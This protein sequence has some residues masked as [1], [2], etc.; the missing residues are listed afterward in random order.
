MDL[1]PAD[2]ALDER[3]RSASAVLLPIGSLEQ[4]GPH[5]PL[6]TDTVVAAT[7]AAEIAAAHPVRR[8]PPVTFSCSHEHAAWPGTVSLSATTLVA[9][10][11]DVAASLHRSGAGALVLVNG[12][13]GNYVL[14]NVVQEASL[15]PL[16][17][18]LFPGE[19]DWDAARAAA[20]CVT[21]GRSDMHAGE[22]ETSILLHAHPHLV[23]PHGPELDHLAD[24]RPHLLSR[25]LRAYTESGVV[26]R[27]SL[28]TAAKGRD[29]LAALVASFADHL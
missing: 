15:G 27:P 20:G 17:M 5:L 18:S 8:L 13:G 10:V 2:T 4:H 16:R 25:G 21:G 26:G 22:L 3:V 24:D 28:A 7:L 14:G 6:T 23:G 11:R 19:A 9:V 29:V 12:H 1:L